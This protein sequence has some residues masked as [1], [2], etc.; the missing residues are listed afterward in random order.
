MGARVNPEEKTRFFV[1]NFHFSCCTL[2]GGHVAWVDLDAPHLQ[3]ALLVDQLVPFL[4]L[5]VCL[6]LLGG[7]FEHFFWHF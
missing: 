5:G 1:K 6:H 7:F 2:H 4:H 3:L